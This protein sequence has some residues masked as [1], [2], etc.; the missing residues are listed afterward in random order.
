[1]I[2]PASARHRSLRFTSIEE[3]RAEIDRV[4]AAER[5]GTL[6]RTGNW[7]TGQV[8]GHLAAWIEYGY[9]GYPPK[10]HPPWFIRWILRFRKGAYLRNDMP[11]GV[12]IP[13]SEQGTFGTEVL[14]TEEGARRLRAALDRLHRREPPKFHSPAFGPMTD[15]E[16]IQLNLRHA[17]LHLG[18]LH[19]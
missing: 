7:T 9:E 15:D 5:A 16:R 10:A 8:L 4:L 13:R 3:L 17:E 11:R 6:T 2:D 14:P 19:P 18:Y 12:R 1:M